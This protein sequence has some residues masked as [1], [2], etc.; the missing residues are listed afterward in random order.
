M[1]CDIHLHT[2]VKIDGIWHHY[3][4]PKVHR[5]YRVFTKMAGVCDIPGIEPFSEPRGLP[6]DATRIVQ[7]SSQ[8]WGSDGHSHSWLNAEEIFQLEKYINKELKLKA[9]HGCSWCN[10]NF[11]F[12]FHGFWGQFWE[13]RVTGGYDPIRKKLQ[14]IRFIFWFDN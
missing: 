1:S 2:E 5:D 14:D 8:F 12:L 9:Q 11:G 6:K 10:A 3:S 4:C 7:L 13:N